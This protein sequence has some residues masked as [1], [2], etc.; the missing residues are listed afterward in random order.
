MALQSLGR[1]CEWW[2]PTPSLGTAL[3]G[4]NAI[5]TTTLIL[6]AS[7]ELVEMIV[8]VPLAGTIDRFG[9]VIAAVANAPDNGLRFS[10]RDVDTSTGLQD[11]TVDQ[12]ATVASGSVA[13]GWLDPGA[14][15][16]SRTVVRNERL[17]C[18]VDFPSF[19]AGDSVTVQS[20]SANGSAVRGVPY[21]ALNGSK[22]SARMAMFA[23]HYT[24]NGGFW[25]P[26]GEPN[27]LLPTSR[28]AISIDT[29][30][31]PD[32][33]G[34]V[35]TLPFP[36]KLNSVLVNLQ[37]TVAASDFDLILYDD[38]WS[39]LAT[40]SFDGDIYQSTANNRWAYLQLASEYSLAANTAYRLV[41]KPTTVNNVSFVYQ[42]FAAATAGMVGGGNI[43]MTQRVDAGTVVNYNNGTDGYRFLEMCLG[44][45]AFDDATGGGGGGG[46]LISGRL[47][48]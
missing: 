41:I 23:L 29:G 12:S 15:G 43:Y 17:A 47:V 24:D 27:M 21:T 48:R 20:W 16:A 2:Y 33:V 19:V 4:W 11:T 45:S 8:H 22:Q 34:N 40:Q 14:F 39:A 13:T 9:A 31:T 3:S 6:D 30:T 44:L 35:F 1:G 10:F 7:G 38:S 42:T 37:S 28:A 46:P 36:A 32:E 5:D 26:I 25:L 18:V